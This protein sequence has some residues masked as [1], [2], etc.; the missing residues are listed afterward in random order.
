MPEVLCKFTSSMFA[1]LRSC[2]MKRELMNNT[3]GI[4]SLSSW[5]KRAIYFLDMMSDLRISQWETY[6][7]FHCSVTCY[8]SSIHSERPADCT[9]SS[10]KVA[11]AWS[12]ATLKAALGRIKATRHRGTE[13]CR[14][15]STEKG[16]KQGE[17]FSSLMYRS[18]TGMEMQL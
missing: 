17:G 12:K 18:Y 16:G 9:D 3:V 15:A 10:S 8:A 13:A 7:S 11:R 6:S 2:W 5:W 1:I 14:F 4:I